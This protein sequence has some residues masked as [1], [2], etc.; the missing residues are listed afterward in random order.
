[1]MKE[2]C[3]STDKQLNIRFWNGELARLAGKSTTDVAGMKYYEVVPRIFLKDRDAVSEVMK[4]RKPMTFKKYYFPCMA[5]GIHADITI[6]PIL[7]DSKKIDGA[8]VMMQPHTMCAVAEELNRSQ[9]L[10]DIGKIASSLAHGVRNPLNAIKGAIVYIR[11]KYRAEPTLVEFTAIMEEEI[12]VLENFITRFLSSSISDEEISAIDINALLKK[13]EVVTALQMHTRNIQYVYELDSVPPVFVNP[14][15]LEQ[16]ILNIM[17]NAI[18]AIQTTGKLNVKTGTASR[19][20]SVFAVI[21]IRDTG[22]GM[23][24]TEIDTLSTG[25]HRGRGFGL[26]ITHEILKYYGGH[27]EISSN[28]DIGTTIKLLLPIS[29]LADIANA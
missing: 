20:G 6:S 9:R 8:K 17:N 2:L 27:L 15:H 1:M 26:F 25:A 11:E 12:S 16:A 3:F 21:E 28:K 13:I 10:I 4:K 23:L 24:R 19:N 18:E 29:Q 14:F 22:A 7:S 5:G